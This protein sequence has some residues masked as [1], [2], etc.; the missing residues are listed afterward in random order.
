MARP[1]TDHQAGMTVPD[2]LGVGIGTEDGTSGSL[3]VDKGTSAI[4]TGSRAYWTVSLGGI[5]TGLSW[6]IGGATG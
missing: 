6:A 1:E 3:G 2:G 5:V 4:G